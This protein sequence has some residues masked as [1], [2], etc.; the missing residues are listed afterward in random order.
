MT[1]FVNFSVSFHFKNPQ[2]GEDFMLCKKKEKQVLF[3]RLLAQ[4]SSINAYVET[5]NFNTFLL[6]NEMVST[7]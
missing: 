4:Q 6:Y 1:V 5:Y 2:Y 7:L 3:V